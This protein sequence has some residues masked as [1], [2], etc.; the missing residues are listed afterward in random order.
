MAAGDPPAA[1]VPR[2]A[3][4]AELDANGST[5]SGTL[6]MERPVQGSFAHTRM[7]SFTEL[8]K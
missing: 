4:S 8:Q 5:D 2:T 7:P 1:A 6:T 3:S